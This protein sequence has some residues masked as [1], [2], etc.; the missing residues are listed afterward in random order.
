MESST[1]SVCQPVR[2]RDPSG[3]QGAAPVSPG[4]IEPIPFQP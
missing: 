4:V 2:L 3:V 1:W